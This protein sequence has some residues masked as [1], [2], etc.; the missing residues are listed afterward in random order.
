[1]VIL[2]AVDRPLFSDVL[3]AQSQ[4]DRNTLLKFFPVDPL[5]GATMA[6]DL[7]LKRFDKT[8][9]NQN[10]VPN[11]M[12]IGLGLSHA[13]SKGLNNDTPLMIARL[14]GYL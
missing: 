2:L 4:I 7:H 5:C 3:V 12:N 14:V 11:S 9:V 10:C 1:M 6:A 8:T 13:F